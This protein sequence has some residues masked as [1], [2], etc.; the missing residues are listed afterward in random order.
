MAESSSA[1]RS[2]STHPPEAAEDQ[3]LVLDLSEEVR[4]TIQQKLYENL[5]KRRSVFL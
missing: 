3:R 1:S 4:E 5:M 2:T